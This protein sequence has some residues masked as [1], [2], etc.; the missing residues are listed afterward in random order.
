MQLKLTMSKFHFL[1]K[2]RTSGVLMGDLVCSTLRPHAWG[3]AV[4]LDV[5]HLG[6]REAKTGESL[7][8]RLWCGKTEHDLL[9]VSRFSLR[10]NWPVVD[11]SLALQ[12]RRG[13]PGE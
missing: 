3:V 10:G 4:A 6:N 8:W 1:P 7:A 12:C 5:S 2:A 9:S 13:P 11:S